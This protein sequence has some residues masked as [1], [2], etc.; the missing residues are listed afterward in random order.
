MQR[1]TGEFT[2]VRAKA[3][4]MLVQKENEIKKLREKT[5]AGRNNGEAKNLNN[6]GI[7]SDDVLSHVYHS[8]ESSS[9]EDDT[10]AHP[11]V[12]NPNKNSDMV[13]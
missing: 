4:E 6:S 7:D 8:D 9:D 12:R 13:D 2:T 1:L 10:L 5:I 3:Q 11:R